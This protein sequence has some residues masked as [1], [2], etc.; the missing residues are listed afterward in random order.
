LP[1][2]DAIG[3]FS[4]GTAALGAQDGNEAGGLV[5]IVTRSGTNT[6]HGSAFEF[7][8]NNYLD[9]D[10]FF[11]TSKDTLHQNQYG[12]TFGGPVRIPKLVDGRDKLFAFAA[13][14][15][16]YSSQPSVVQRR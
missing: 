7:V 3:Q 13:F 16:T 10:N 14:Q 1:F 11:S 15:H 8:R 12:G 9:A 5:N 6:Y 4:V 2:P